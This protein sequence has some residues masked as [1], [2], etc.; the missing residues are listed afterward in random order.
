MQLPEGLDRAIERSMHLGNCGIH[1]SDQ[2][3][4][5]SLF[6]LG[7]LLVIV[8]RGGYSPLE[9]PIVAARLSRAAFSSGVI[10][11]VVRAVR[12]TVSFRAR[13]GAPRGITMTL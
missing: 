7:D 4:E 9:T 2:R 3:G 5:L 1:F 11:T 6:F 12:I 13:S 8:D 10:K